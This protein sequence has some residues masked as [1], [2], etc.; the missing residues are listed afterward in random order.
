MMRLDAL[1]ELPCQDAAPGD[2]QAPL[3]R[4]LR[5]GEV[6]HVL[7]DAGE[8]EPPRDHAGAAGRLG[9]RRQLFR[10]PTDRQMMVL[11]VGRR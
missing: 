1:A 2:R 7:F 10:R 5:H 11:P 3:C 9:K 6:E 8:I 4:W